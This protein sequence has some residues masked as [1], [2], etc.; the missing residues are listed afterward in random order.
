MC[1][2]SYVVFKIVCILLITIAT[3]Q[4]VAYLSRELHT[5]GFGVNTSIALAL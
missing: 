3:F 1:Y 5:L 4:I 2:T